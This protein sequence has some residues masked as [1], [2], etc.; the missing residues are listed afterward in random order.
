MRARSA[1]VTL[2]QRRLRLNVALS[3]LRQHTTRARYARWPATTHRAAFVTAALIAC[4]F[5]G[6][7]HD[8]TA[9]PS[10]VPAGEPDDR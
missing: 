9:R 3:L 2:S 5:I 4:T 6:G 7:A 8:A 1:C 10:K